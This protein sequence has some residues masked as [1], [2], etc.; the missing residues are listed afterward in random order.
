MLSLVISVFP[1]ELRLS[2]KTVV[3]V[4]SGKKCGCDGGGD[5]QHSLKGVDA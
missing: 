3:V 4:G 1:D 2:V 5:K